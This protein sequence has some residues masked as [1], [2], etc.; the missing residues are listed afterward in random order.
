MD[1]WVRVAALG[2]L[3]PDGL[4][5]AVKADGIG[6]AV[7]QWEGRLHAVEDLCPHLGFPLSEGIVQEGEII[8]GWHGWRICLDDGSCRR[9]KQRAKV[10]AC[11]VRGEDVFVQI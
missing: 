2:D 8:C 11:E 6:I 5:L 3:L 10:F 4:G 9:E 1:E 7:F